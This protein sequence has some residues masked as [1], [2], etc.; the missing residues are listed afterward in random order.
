MGRK[1]DRFSLV[2]PKPW[3][4]KTRRLT[5]ISSPQTALSPSRVPVTS[6]PAPGGFGI[7][8][9]AT[10][11]CLRP[12]HP[13]LLPVGM[14]RVCGCLQTPRVPLQVSALE[15]TGR[16]QAPSLTA[17]ASMSSRIRDLSHIAPLLPN[18]GCTLVLQGP[19]GWGP[20][21]GLLEDKARKGLG[22]GLSA[23]PPGASGGRGLQGAWRQASRLPRR[24]EQPLKSLNDPLAAEKP[25]GIQPEGVLLCGPAPLA[26]SSSHPAGSMSGPAPSPPGLSPQRRVGPS[27]KTWKM[28]LGQFR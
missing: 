12:P 17:E 8:W 6:P 13:W 19:C 28:L 16:G 18:G 3:S 25:P 9:E 5:W 22:E 26:A 21:R 15:W 1:A 11:G 24:P 4:P 23:W 7:C 27:V 14:C 20:N 10:Q 2:H